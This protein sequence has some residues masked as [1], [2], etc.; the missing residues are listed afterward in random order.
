MPTPAPTTA[1]T[2]TAP[3][4]TAVSLTDVR[5]TY[6]SGPQPVHA[7]RGVSL[8]VTKGSFTAVMGPSGSG[9]ST[10]LNVA[11][12]LDQPSSGRIVIGDT[13][14]S[15]LS[16]E[17]LTTFRRRRVGFIFQSYNLLPHLSVSENL[18]LPWW[19]DNQTP[20][21]SREAELLHA[22]GLQDMAH[23]LPTELS[24][25]QAQRVAIA[26]ALAT[27]PDVIFADEP[28]GALDSHTGATILATLRD[29][30]ATYQQT[31]VMVT[32]DPQVAAAADEVVFLADGAV[33]DRAVS[34]S[35]AQISQRVLELGR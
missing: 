27:Q 19:L 21:P 11:A 6:S 25:G 15:H 28:T 13:D 2:S 3:T 24:G 32:H 34:A 14:I 17:K 8:A 26:R 18:R 22:V 35:A 33:V 12:G 4:T 20:D 29:A 1:P 30:V 16:A 5:K 7:L 31:L 10:L 23:R 9:K